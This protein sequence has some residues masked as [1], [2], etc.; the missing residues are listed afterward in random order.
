MGIAPISFSGISTYSADF[1]KILERTVAIAGQPISLLQ[2]EQ[3]KVLQQK[4]L[5]N[6]L[7]TTTEALTNA[8]NA[9]GEL[10]ASKALAGTSSNSAKVAINTVTATSP[11]SYTIS[12]ITSLARAASASSAG[13]ATAT[14]AVSATGS[15]RLTFNG[16]TSDIT[17]NPSENTL[18]GLRDKISNLG[19]GVTATILTTGTGATPFY[20]SITANTSGEKPIT[21]TDDPSGAATNLLATTDNGANAVFKVNGASVSKSSNIVNDVVSGVSFTLSGTTSGAETVSL[22]LATSRANLSSKLQSFATAYNSLLSDSDTQV[23]ESAGLLT[24]DL[25]VREIKN[26]LRSVASY[27]GSGAIKGLADIG[28]SFGNDGKA[29]LDTAVFDSLS[30][31]QIQDTFTFLGST[32]TGFGGLQNKLKQISDPVVGLIAV[33]TA[34]YDETDKRLTSR[35][36]ELGERLSNLQKSSAERL[37]TVD[38]LLGRIESQGQIIEASYKS[39]QL[40]LFGKQD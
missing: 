30:D 15:V 11:A 21:L 20:L 17:L 38:A 25:T 22:T 9:L 7:R 33:Q 23:G 28:I 13:Y 12:E 3:A 29:K 2:N 26:A 6:G 39:L 5:A 10:G 35:I 27:A 16:T 40:A 34:K 14:T 32:T 24:G 37:A 18:T 36:A 4:T 1:Q 8:V 19:A 31:Q